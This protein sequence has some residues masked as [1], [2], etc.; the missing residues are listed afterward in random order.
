VE[1]A[2]AAPKPRKIVLAPGDTLAAS[3]AAAIAF[4]LQA[5]E[6]EAPAAA[7]G[8]IEPI[9]QLRVATRRLRAALD[10]FARIINA[11]HARLL[12]RDLAWI[13]HA[14]GAV[15]ECDIIAETIH[16]RAPK[17]DDPLANALASL[18]TPLDA[19]RTAARGALSELL[20]SKR[21]AAMIARLRNP[22]LNRRGA[23]AP[24]GGAAAGLL[25]PVVR[26]IRR[27]GAR[28]RDD[29]P[30]EV[31]H[32]LRVRI[33]RLRYELE[34][35]AALGGKRHRKAL[36]RLEAMQDLLGTYNDVCVTIEWLIA[37]PA[38]EGAAP[39]G[40]LAAGAM[41]QSLTRRKQKLGRRCRQAWRKFERSEIISDVITEIRRAGR[42]PALVT[43]P[44]PA[45]LP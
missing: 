38:A 26:S 35:L 16:T 14:A 36:K 13:A 8:E 31:V 45:N 23:D 11:T 30:P 20:G 21:F 39:E 12:H 1:A 34:M 40:V 44:A 32:H 28:L 43:E 42:I 9:H 41:A 5:L 6:R 19:R 37:F 33:K 3:A 4:A 27:A 25:Q 22:R 10:L 15:R 24:L 2:A 29:A 7:A 18:Y 17:L